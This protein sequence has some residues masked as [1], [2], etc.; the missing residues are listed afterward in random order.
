MTTLLAVDDGIA[1]G[2][3]NWADVFFLVGAIFGALAG[4][5]YALGITATV[6]NNPPRL[7]RMGT[8]PRRIRGGIR[9]IRV[10]PAV[11]TLAAMLAD[12]LY[13]SGGVILIIVILILLWLFFFR[14]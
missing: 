11:S 7:P 1:N 4:L 9:R 2:N 5:A 6:D 14:R 12:G 10:V 13:I 8:G 3:L